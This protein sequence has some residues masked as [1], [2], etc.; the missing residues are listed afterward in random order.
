[1]ESEQPGEGAERLELMES[2]QPGEAPE[3]L[4]LLGGRGALLLSRQVMHPL[5]HLHWPFVCTFYDLPFVY[6]PSV[7]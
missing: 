4:E 7:P 3:R 2:E 1:M 6:L 5:L